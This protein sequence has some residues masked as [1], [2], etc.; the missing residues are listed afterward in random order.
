MK[1]TLQ[2]NGIMVIESESDVE[3]Y[4]LN[5]WVNEEGDLKTR[6]KFDWS[7]TDVHPTEE[8]AELEAILMES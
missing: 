5:K 4:A 7:H 6:M 1:A 2:S 3:S 8:D